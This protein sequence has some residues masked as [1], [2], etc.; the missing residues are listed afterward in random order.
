MRL[1]HPASKVEELSAAE[2]S[3]HAAM[4]VVRSAASSVPAVAARDAR[5]CERPSNRCLRSV[6]ASQ[7]LADQTMRHTISPA[8]IGLRTLS[9]TQGEP[10]VVA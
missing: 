4:T 6:T 9:P 8:A 5:L 10:A 7:N 2:T 1:T 3:A